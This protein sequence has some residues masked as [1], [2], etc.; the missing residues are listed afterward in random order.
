LDLLYLALR[1]EDDGPETAQEALDA[2]RAHPSHPYLAN[3]AGSQLRRRRD[4]SGATAAFTTASAAVP[5]QDGAYLERA[6]LARITDEA[7]ASQ[8]K[9]WASNSTSLAS[10]L[11]L[12]DGDV[13]DDAER[14]FSLLTRGELNGA[15]QLARAQP[16]ILAIVL[17]LAAASDGA[18]Q[19]L[20]DEALGMLEQVTDPAALWPSLALAERELRPHAALD[21][22][23]AKLDSPVAEV[24]RFADSKFLK[25]DTAAVEAA[26]WRLPAEDQ[27]YACVMALVRVSVAAPAPC[28]GLAKAALFGSERPY[29]R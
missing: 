26:L 7:S 5:L 20:V 28:R 4:Y 27:P 17:P 9:A 16:S 29:F 14:S 11:A 10:L 21:A 22:K 23:V 8:L 1:C 24:S 3:M 19:T 25:G 15:V 12:E 2:Y 13:S 18:S 6:R